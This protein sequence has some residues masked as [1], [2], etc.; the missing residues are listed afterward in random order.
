MIATRSQLSFRKP[1]PAES[2]QSM[3]DDNLSSP[4]AL[5]NKTL[6]FGKIELK[7]DEI[8]ISGWTWSG[9]AGKAIAIRSITTF[10][11]WTE[12]E[13][14][15]FR[16]KINGLEINGKAPIRGRIKKGL[17]LWQLKMEGDERVDLRRR[18]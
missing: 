1:A 3:A 13:G 7:A 9:P 2:H 12:R 10:E 14:T 18:F 11:T 16:L 5:E 4:V 6:W 8:L 15:N 17:G